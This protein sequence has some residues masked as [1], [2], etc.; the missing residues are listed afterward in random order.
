MVDD[1]LTAWLVEQDQMA[2]LGYISD[3]AYACLAQD[4]DDPASFDRGM[5]PFQLLASLK[6]VSDAL[7]RRPSLEGT[8]TGANLAMPALRVVRQPNHARFVIYSVPDDVAAEFDCEGRL[9][10]STGEK[11]NRTY[12]NYYG[13]TFIVAGERS[14]P[15]ALLWARDRGY[16]KIVS[17]RAGFDSAPAPVPDAATRPRG[18]AARAPADETLVAATHAFLTRWL[19]A[20]DSDAAMAYLSPRSY[21][22]YDLLRDP[23]QPA[24]NSPA[25]AAARIRAALASTASGL[26]SRRLQD[27]IEAVE[28]VHDAVRPLAHRY[29]NLYSLSSVPEGLARA[30]DCARRQKGEPLP[31]RVAGTPEYGS[32]TAMSVRFRMR[33]GEAPVLRTLWQREDGAWKITAYDV[34]TP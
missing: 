2:A 14:Q 33:S 25:D 32:S 4:A 18:T 21:P 13:A 31:D 30:V 8:T 5:A 24:S 11:V 23:A 16:W 12:G 6:E 15:L 26:E 29:A 19:E 34:E 10:P 7:G 17:W 28:P 9:R 22:C 3:R 27:V 1:F 20:R